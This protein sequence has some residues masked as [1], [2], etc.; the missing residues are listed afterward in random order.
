MDGSE[1]RMRQAAHLMVQDLAGSLALVTT[2]E[3]LRT[4]ILS[5]IRSMSV[6]S[7]FPEVRR[8]LRAAQGMS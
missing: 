4:Q 2:K 5:N 7:G 8:R 3:P 1:E 6:S